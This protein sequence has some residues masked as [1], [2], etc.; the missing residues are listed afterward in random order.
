VRWLIVVF[1]CVIDEGRAAF[2]RLGDAGFRRRAL[3]GSPAALERR[4]M[5]LLVPRTI[6]SGEAGERKEP[7]RRSQGRKF[8]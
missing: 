6:V 4:F 7:K 8:T 2:W 5:V 3:T 1:D